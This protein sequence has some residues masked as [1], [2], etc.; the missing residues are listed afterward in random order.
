M[1]RIMYTCCAD[2]AGCTHLPWK[3]LRQVQQRKILRES[4]L[5][6]Q[7][8]QK[9]LAQVNCRSTRPLLVLASPP[10]LQQS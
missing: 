10:S 9:W 8:S 6:W 1:S 5:R 3:A 4:P 2:V 7:R